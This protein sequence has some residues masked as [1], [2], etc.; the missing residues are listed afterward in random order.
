MVTVHSAPNSVTRYVQLFG[1]ATLGSEVLE[2]NFDS[3]FKQ[4]AEVSWVSSAASKVRDPPTKGTP[5]DSWT[6]T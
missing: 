6:R 4:L 2:D 3:G 1:G 5:S